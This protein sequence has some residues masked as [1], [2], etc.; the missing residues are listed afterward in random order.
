MDRRRW[1]STEELV[2]RNAQA[3]QGARDRRRARA[4]VGLD[5][6]QST[7]IGVPVWEVDDARNERR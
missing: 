1:H 4:A 7:I 5:N 3:T 2:D 6:S